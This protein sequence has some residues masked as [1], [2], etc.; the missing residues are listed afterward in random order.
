MNSKLVESIRIGEHQEITL[1]VLLAKL[2]IVETVINHAAFYIEKTRQTCESVCIPPDEAVLTD[3]KE[4]LADVCF[5][6]KCGCRG[7]DAPGVVRTIAES[8]DTTMHKGG[9]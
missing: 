3:A 8:V 6:I 4:Q 2:E 5:A 9:I 1:E 7:F